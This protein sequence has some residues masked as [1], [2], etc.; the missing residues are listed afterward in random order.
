MI[1]NVGLTIEQI[2]EAED[3]PVDFVDCPECGGSYYI[4]PLSGEARN[5]LD[6]RQ[7]AGDEFN[8]RAWLVANAG[9]TEN[10]ERWE[11]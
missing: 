2:L 8:L 7:T 11:W 5:E 1:T 10:G 6:A 3:R 4:R 9:C